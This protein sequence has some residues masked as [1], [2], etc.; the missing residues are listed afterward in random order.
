M[1]NYR[2]LLF[3]T[4]LGS[5][6]VIKLRQFL[7]FLSCIFHSTI[8]VRFAFV[9]PKRKKENFSSFLWKN[10]SEFECW[11]FF[12]F[13]LKKNKLLKFHLL[14]SPASRI[15]FPSFE[16]LKFFFDKSFEYFSQPIT[17]PHHVSFYL[18]LNTSIVF[19]NRWTTINFKRKPLID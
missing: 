3:Q 10:P 4:V 6:Y 2:K 19:Y 1:F 7:F 11:F 18:V 16:I 9:S 15:R 13:F 8:L 12:F 14:L 5:V 17:K